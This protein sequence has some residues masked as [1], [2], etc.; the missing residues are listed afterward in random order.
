MNNAYSL[1]IV[2]L[3]VSCPNTLPANSL[4]RALSTNMQSRTHTRDSEC[5]D[6][7]SMSPVIV[8]SCPSRVDCAKKTVET[9]FNIEDYLSSNQT[10]LVF[11]QVV[12]LSRSHHFICLARTLLVCLKIYSK[13]VRSFYHFDRNTLFSSAWWLTRRLFY[14][15]FFGRPTT[16]DEIYSMSPL[17]PRRHLAF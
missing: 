10:L 13:C 4:S 11:S 6:Q 2:I 7:W 9:I 12:P 15:H 3:A 16:K 5:E 17:G 1:V 8:S 14:I